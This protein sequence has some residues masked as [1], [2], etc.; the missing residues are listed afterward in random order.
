[1]VS[2]C[3]LAV[4]DARFVTGEFTHLVVGE[5]KRTLK[6][7][8]AMAR[9]AWVLEPNWVYASVE[10]EA[11]VD[12]KDHVVTT[13]PTCALDG[14][15]IDEPVRWLA[16]KRVF[17]DPS[18]VPPVSEVAELVKAVGGDITKAS[19]ATLLII[20]SEKNLSS[21]LQAPQHAGK[22]MVPV[23][24]FLDSIMA[25]EFLDIKRYGGGIA[26]EGDGRSSPGY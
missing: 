15:R 9:G 25:R 8:K 26:C 19:D 21:M 13:I 22:T 4:S 18:V 7:L 20:H 10:A 5:R 3:V 1:V 17:V 2:L 11:W 6:L 12:E 24:W 14:T 16:E 23:A